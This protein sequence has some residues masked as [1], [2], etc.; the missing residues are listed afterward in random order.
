MP[1]NAAF[2]FSSKKKFKKEEGAVR[3]AALYSLKKLK[4]KETAVE[5]FLV[6]DE[7]MER[8]NRK[9]RKKRKPTNVLSFETPV[10]VPRPDLGNRRFIGEIFLAPDFAAAKGDELGFLTVHAVL[11]L[12]GY[13]HESEKRSIIM[14]NLERKIWNQL[15]QKS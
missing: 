15:C 8:L 3:K 7:A 1:G 11:H 2:V 10:P 6:S 5:I 12:L 14:N 4:K 13:T 9:Y